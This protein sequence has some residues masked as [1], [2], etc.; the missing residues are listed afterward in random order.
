[1]IRDRNMEMQCTQEDVTHFQG[2][3]KGA[4]MQKFTDSYSA[5]NE[6][7]KECATGTEKKEEIL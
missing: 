6:T 4:R 1:M 7:V 5:R 3:L 2:E